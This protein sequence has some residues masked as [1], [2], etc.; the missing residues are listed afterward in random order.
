MAY[1]SMSYFDFD[2][3]DQVGTLASL[4]VNISHNKIH[5][6][7]DNSSNFGFTKDHCKTINCKITL[8]PIAPH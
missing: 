3:L 6:L 5:S 8:L 1:N 7:V 2:Y 4:R